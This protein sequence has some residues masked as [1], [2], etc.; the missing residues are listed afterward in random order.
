MSTTL[1]P[2]PPERHDGDQLPPV[3]QV[4]GRALRLSLG[5]LLIAAG[6]G[7]A[8]YLVGEG[9]VRVEESRASHLDVDRVVFDLDANGSIEVVAHDGPEVVVHERTET[10]V[11]EVRTSQSVVD[12]ELRIA[13]EG[14][15]GW[16]GMLVN[17]CGASYVVAVPAATPLDGRISHGAVR[18]SDLDDEVVLRTG[19]GAI[20]ATGLAG[21]TQLTTSHGSITVRGVRGHVEA[22]TGHGSVTVEQAS[23]GVA[24]ATSH[25]SVTVTQ[26]RGAVRAT[27]GQGSVTLREISGDVDARTSHGSIEVDGVTGDDVTLDTGHGSLSFRPA[28]APPN[29]LLRTSHGNI[30]VFLPRDAPAYALSTDAGDRTANVEV[31]TD[32]SAAHRMDLHTGH[33]SIHVGYAG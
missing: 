16:F 2:A 25:G 17:R 23:D 12:G 29:V 3:A 1:S 20:E 18:L 28:A 4:S 7:L 24:A 30:E 31:S 26:A 22:E 5:L 11:R 27:T 14:C 21:P 9:T 19:H 13:S 33:G 15:R 8:L 32:P 6:V 10:T